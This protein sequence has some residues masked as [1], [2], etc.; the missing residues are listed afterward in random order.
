MLEM[1]CLYWLL[2]HSSE[3]AGDYGKFKWL[4]WDAMILLDAALGVTV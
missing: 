1:I 2:E 3:K 4:L